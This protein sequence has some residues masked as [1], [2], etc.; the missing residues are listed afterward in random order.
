MPVF[1]R[2]LFLRWILASGLVAVFAKEARA[3]E[4]NQE[5]VVVQVDASA[6]SLDAEKLRAALAEELGAIAV[7]P[8]DPRAVG[9]KGTLTIE[10]SPGKHAMRIT[11][12]ARATPTV[13]SVVLPDDPDAARREAVL[14]AG[15]LARDEGAELARELR[16]KSKKTEP[17]SV[18]GNGAFRPSRV[19][20]AEVLEYYVR[21][22]QAY[23]RALLI[24]GLGVGVV[25]SAVGFAVWSQDDKKTGNALV[26]FGV[27]AAAYAGILYALAPES[28][29]EALSTRARSLQLELDDAWGQATETERRERRSGAIVSFVVSGL[30]AGVGS[31]ALLDD[32]TWGVGRV[33]NGIGLLVLGAV[34]GISGVFLAT[35]DGPIESGFRVF[36]KT[37]GRHPPQAARLRLDVAPVAGGAL[38]GIGGVF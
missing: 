11:Y 5:I 22:E 31:W 19:D 30:A 3:A 25:S 38:A 7:S 10:A 2:M 29:Y 32:K 37:T 16:E 14:V 28:P 17:P 6:A 15:N 9:A 13:R 1:S 4:E 8:Q 27:G 36:E 21:Q 26:G 35:T 20:V 24:S 23:K 34:A 18:T 33:Q 12:V